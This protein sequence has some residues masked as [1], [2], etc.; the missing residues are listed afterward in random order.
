MQRGQYLWPTEYT[1]R[2]IEDHKNAVERYSPE[3]NNLDGKGK[4][5]RGFRT[6]N[7]QVCLHGS[8]RR[9]KHR[10]QSGVCKRVVSR[11]TASKPML[12]RP[13]SKAVGTG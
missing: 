2:E 5:E 6:G 9:W 8:C 7:T 4:R 3:E 10:A 12:P 11:K 1:P 13:K